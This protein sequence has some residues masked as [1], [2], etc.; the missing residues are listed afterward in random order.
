MLR[1]SNGA[2]SRVGLAVSHISHLNE[3]EQLLLYLEF[4][5]VI[6]QYVVWGILRS[7]IIHLMTAGLELLGTAH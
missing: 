2:N 6:Y 5:R 4:E 1:L 7:S 3:H